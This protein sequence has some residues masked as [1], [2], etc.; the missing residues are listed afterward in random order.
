MEV[1]TR[2]SYEI[3]DRELVAEGTDLW[4]QVLTLA[5]GQCVPWHEAL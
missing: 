2:G 3:A 1:R 4:V 5:A